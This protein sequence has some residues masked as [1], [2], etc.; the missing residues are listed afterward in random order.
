MTYFGEPVG[1]KPSPL[2][3]PATVLALLG[4]ATVSVTAASEADWGKTLIYGLITLILALWLFLLRRQARRWIVE[5]RVRQ[6]H[7]P[8]C[9]YDLREQSGRCPESGRP[10]PYSIRERRAKTQ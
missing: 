1:R 8:H 3:A 2:L 4:C 6:G 9:E 10:V 7:C 5:E